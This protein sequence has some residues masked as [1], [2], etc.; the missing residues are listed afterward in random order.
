[1]TIELP[2][3]IER[4]QSAHDRRDTT[5]ALE[6]FADDATVIDDGETYIGADGIRSWLEQAASE[7][8]YTRTL[9]AVERDGVDD[10]GNDRYVVH[11]HVAGNFPGGEVD[12]AY[13]FEITDGLI[14]HLEIL[15]S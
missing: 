1:M 14:R 12:L 9:T 5:T 4:Y 11:N 8:T 13:R 6:T 2:D 10:A 7:F 15:P 3:V